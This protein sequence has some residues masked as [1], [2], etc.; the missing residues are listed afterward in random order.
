MTGSFGGRNTVLLAVGVIDAVI[1][2]RAKR[3]S[4]HGSL[5]MVSDPDGIRRKERLILLVHAGGDIGPP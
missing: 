3:V 4:A 5:G 2:S 1:G